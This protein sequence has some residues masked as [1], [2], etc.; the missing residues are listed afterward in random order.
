LTVHDWPH[1]VW[2]NNFDVDPPIMFRATHVPIDRYNIG[3]R[4]SHFAF[5]SPEL[6]KKPQFRTY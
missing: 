6:Y 2:K 1:T 4:P 5:F 3:N